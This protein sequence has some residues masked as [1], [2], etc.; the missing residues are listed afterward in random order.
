MDVP[1]YVMPPVLASAMIEELTALGQLDIIEQILQGLAVRKDGTLL[2]M[3]FQKLDEF[4]K[5]GQSLKSLPE[6][7]KAQLL[8]WQAQ[9]ANELH[10]DFEEK[11]IN[12]VLFC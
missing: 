7:I 10:L 6:A 4:I 1:V 9:G 11:A 8:D 12:D 5:V 3:A 2:K